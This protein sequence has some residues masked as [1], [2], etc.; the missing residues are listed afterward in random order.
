MQ[1]NPNYEN[2]AQDR[3]TGKS[4]RPCGFFYEV[5]CSVVDKHTGMTVT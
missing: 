5:T 3:K 4:H 1:K 2:A